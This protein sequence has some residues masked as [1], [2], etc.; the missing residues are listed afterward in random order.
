MR[1]YFLYSFL[2]L[3]AVGLGVASETVLKQ[4]WLQWVGYAAIAVAMGYLLWTGP[5]PYRL[6]GDFTKAYYFAG[7]EVLRS[8][9]D[10]YSDACTRGYVNIP[11][12]AYLFTPFAGFDANTAA[13]LM[14]LVGAGATIAACYLSLQLTGV[15]GW[16]SLALVGLFVASGPVYYNLR[17][18]NTT[19][20][21]LLLLLGAVFCLWKQ[22]GFLAGALVAIAG[23]IKIP[24]LLLAG[25]F[26]LRGRWQAV[27]GFVA[28]LLAIVGT[29]LL[30]FG[31]ELHV[32]WY[33]QC[34]QPFAGKPVSAFNVQSVDGFLARLLG[35][36]PATW[37]PMQVNW[38]FKLLRYSLLSLLAGAVVWAFW[39]VK[40]P[41][42]LAAETL[43]FVTVLV[44]ALLMSPISWTHYYLLLLLPF[45]LYL[46]KKLPLPEPRW[47]LRWF[48]VSAVLVSL[49]V[50]LYKSPNS[51][52]QQLV[53]RV[54]LSHYFFG[55]VLLLGLLLAARWQTARAE[56]AGSG[57]PDIASAY[58]TYGE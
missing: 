21:V 34:V 28:A 16:R 23:I 22:Q 58:L 52:L 15:T 4:R 18:G 54:F 7:Q 37:M 25:Y 55:G 57:K 49:P 36:N 17:L 56:M 13:N 50:T 53:D 35:G 32:D 46:G 45:A 31:P 9:K 39:R 29:S 20:Y 3:L 6:F 40:P 43:E 12:V 44:L 24:I 41:R 19:Q 10:L 30:L 47:A 5:E 2:I 38:T 42:T 33:Q 1:I 14:A 11:I 26:L 48:A 8:S 51:L 27:T